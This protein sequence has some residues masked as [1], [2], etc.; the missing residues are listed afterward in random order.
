MTKVI[1]GAVQRTGKAY[2]G[3]TSG[4]VTAPD[5]TAAPL[6]ATQR[7]CIEVFVQNEP[8][9]GN[10]VR[11]GGAARQDFILTPGDNVL[12]GVNDLNDVY[13]AGIGGTATVR[14]LALS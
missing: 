1:R 12:L 13:V 8:G 9:Q 3:L 10:N 4:Y 14:W 7:A 6:S 2:S 5:G 11:V